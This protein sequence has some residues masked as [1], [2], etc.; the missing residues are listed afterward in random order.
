[1]TPIHRSDSIGFGNGMR[2]PTA[3]HRRNEITYLG[4]WVDGECSRLFRNYAR[5]IRSHIRSLCFGRGYD[6]EHLSGH[7]QQRIALVSLSLLRRP[8]ASEEFSWSFL[9]KI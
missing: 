8:Q 5:H 3:G 9:L 2:G 1:M 4:S 7:P 6:A